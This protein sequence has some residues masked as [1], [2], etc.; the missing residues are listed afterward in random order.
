MTQNKRRHLVEQYRARV[1]LKVIAARFGTTPQHVSRIALAAGCARRKGALRR[2]LSET[3]RG[4]APV[5]VS[6]RMQRGWDLQ[7]ALTT[8]P[9]RY[10][11][12]HA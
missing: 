3:G 6:Q 12:H 11:R 5:L 1:P 9:R 10:A 8:P 4:I 2:L 7:A